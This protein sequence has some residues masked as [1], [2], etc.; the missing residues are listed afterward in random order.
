MAADAKNCIT[1]K[2][3]FYPEK[4]MVY[5]AEIVWNIS[6]SIVYSDMT[7]KKCSGIR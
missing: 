6:G 4:K 5:L 2:T 3:T 7:R 1:N